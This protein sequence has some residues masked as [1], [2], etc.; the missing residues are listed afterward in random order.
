MA[1]YGHTL[2]LDPD[3]W[4]LTLDGAGNIATVTGDF[5]AAQNVANAVRL[6][7]DDAYFNPERG[8]PHFAITLGQKPALS[9]FRSRVRKAALE[10]DGV[11]NA[12]CTQLEITQQDAESATGEKIPPR[13][14]TGD[15]QLT[16][17]DGAIYA[18]GI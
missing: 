9:V 2:T 13:T 5:A 3:A 10:V 12:D 7:T 1:D 15:I 4:D 14:L 6:F 11:Q 16:M 17:K 8:I 18:I